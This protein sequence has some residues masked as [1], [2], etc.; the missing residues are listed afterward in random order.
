MVLGATLGGIGWVWHL[1]ILRFSYWPFIS[2]LG[3]LL[4]GLIAVAYALSDLGWISLPRPRIMDAVPLSWWR[5][6]QPYGA[7][8][9]YGA[10]LGLGVMTRVRYGA[11]YIICLWCIAKGNI[12]Y[13]ATLLGTF[14][15]LRALTL[16]PASL[17]V[18]GHENNDQATCDTHVKGIIVN[19][20]QAKF[21]I[22]PALLLFGMSIILSGLF[23]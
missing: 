23:R 18:Y 14:G 5:S 7:S 19:F 22:G 11:F 12:A 15:L 8:V 2:T 1:I 3:T 4:V 13:G 9:A 10:A 16:I 17:R 6:W 20:K 21:I